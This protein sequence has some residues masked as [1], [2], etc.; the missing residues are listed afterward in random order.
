MNY[1]EV[2]MNK[3]IKFPSIEQFRNVVRN[4]T[5]R[6]RYK[7]KGELGEA[8]FDPYIKLPTLKFEGTVKLHGTNAAVC[9]DY[10]G[11]LWCQSRENII[12]PEK[13]NA[14]FA[15]FILQNEEKLRNSI[16]TKIGFD[17]LHGIHNF[18]KEHSLCI[19]GEWCGQGIQKGVAI[20]SIPKMFV[21]FAMAI[22]DREDNKKY[23]TREQVKSSMVGLNSSHAGQIFCIYDYPTF[24]IT[25]DF[26]N[27]HNSQNI[28]NEI[29]EGVE[30]E[31][32]V[33]K[34]FGISG[35]GEGVVWRCVD[36]GW[37]DSGY[38]FKVKGEAHSKSKVK[39]LATVDIDRINDINE[40][41]ARL[42]HNGRLEQGLQTVFDTLNGG[43]VD[44]KRTGE[45]IRFVMSDIFKEESDLIAAS[46]FSG[47]ELNSP[48]SKIVRDFLM[49]NLDF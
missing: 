34:A 7:G 28:L 37:E 2:M 17:S 26:E 6:A 48:I 13:D 23:L 20:S 31:C 36:E 49:K 29:T 41:S 38:W 39:T 47:K 19:W 16:V 25:I 24:D 18:T 15:S 44:I 8:I 43:E 22:V 4:V 14:G 42:A 10:D 46:G 9:F 11:N 5:Q 1:W 3:L 30:K 40:L 32:P 12:T 27:P 35:I 33:G 21:V 45:L